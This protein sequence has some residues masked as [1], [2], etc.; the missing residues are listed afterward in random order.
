MK[1][2]IFILF[3]NILSF[4]TTNAMEQCV[5]KSATKYV[6]DNHCI[7][8]TIDEQSVGIIVFR[9]VNNPINTGWIE[10]FK[11][12]ENQQGKGIGLALFIKCIKYFYRHDCNRIIWDATP[13]NVN[14]TI[15]LADLKLIY[16]RIIS[17]ISIPGVSL[18]LS[19][20]DSH[21]HGYQ[22]PSLGFELILLP[23]RTR[24]NSI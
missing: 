23:E 8:A 11:V 12:K 13:A 18:H 9:I 16:T 19:I 17:K 1:R 10:L 4:F 22:T 7:H 14:D 5:I 20:G 21:Y 3:F 24:K 15:T 2:F 6:D